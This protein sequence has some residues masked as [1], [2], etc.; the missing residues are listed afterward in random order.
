MP[1][2]KA[3]RV[4]LEFLNPDK[5]KLSTRLVEGTEEK[6][7]RLVTTVSFETDTNPVKIAKLLHLV[8]EKAPIYVNIGSTQSVFDF[9]QQEI[10]SRKAGADGQG[11]K[12]VADAEQVVKNKYKGEVPDPATT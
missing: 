12:V 9:F 6:P 10:A 8:K 3:M 7:E 4:H 1:E 11:K 2:P 5:I